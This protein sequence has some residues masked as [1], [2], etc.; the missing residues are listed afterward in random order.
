MGLDNYR[1]AAGDPIFWRSLLN[2]T[3][4][5]VMSLVCQVGFSLVLA[6][7]LEEFVHQRCGASCGRIYFIPAVISITV[8]GILFSF[9]YNP[10]IGLLNGLWTLSAWTPG[11]T[12]GWVS[13]G[14]RCGASS[15]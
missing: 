13:R 9:I 3:V 11:H 10:Q 2:N 15:R 4:F 8:A 5:A 1:T 12:P 7:V 14:R 6:A